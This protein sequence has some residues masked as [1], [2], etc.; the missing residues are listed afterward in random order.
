VTTA[1][2]ALG[3]KAAPAHRDAPPTWTRP[4]LLAGRG[5]TDRPR[6]RR[7]ALG[8]FS[9]G[10]MRLVLAL[11]AFEGE[12]KARGLLDRQSACS[13]ASDKGALLRDVLCTFAD[14]PPQHLDLG[15]ARFHAGSIADL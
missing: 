5:A 4:E 9:F 2:T 12:Q 7:D 11:Q 13:E 10:K 8:P 6:G 1:D 15:F 3:R 14:M